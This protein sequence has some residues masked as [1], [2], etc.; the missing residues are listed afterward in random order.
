MNINNLTPSNLTWQ[1]VSRMTPEKFYKE[2][3]GK[4]MILY[5]P[6]H[7]IKTFGGNEFAD[8]SKSNKRFMY[9]NFGQGQEA[10][11]VFFTDITPETCKIYDVEFCRNLFFHPHQRKDSNY[12]L[13]KVIPQLKSLSHKC[14]H[15]SKGY[16]PKIFTIDT[17]HFEEYHSEC[18]LKSFFAPYLEECGKMKT[19]QEEFMSGLKEVVDKVKGRYVHDLTTLRKN[20]TWN[21]IC[22]GGANCEF[23]AVGYSKAV[24]I[25][26]T[27]DHYSVER[28]WSVAT[29]EMK[30]KDYWGSQYLGGYKITDKG[31]QK[32]DA[33]ITENFKIVTNGE[34]QEKIFFNNWLKKYVLENNETEKA[35]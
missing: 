14:Y 6:V 19:A 26:S 25:R 15:E 16:S 23:I 35:A 33:Y 1:K 5:L 30:K 32:I 12:E 7:S 2:F 27:N 29:H 34:K 31:Y 4:T 17:P 8:A 10:T 28:P 24:G 11:L 13:I 20:S 3:G 21:Y 18:N 9:F 22:Y